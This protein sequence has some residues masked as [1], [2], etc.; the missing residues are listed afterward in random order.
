[1]PRIVLLLNKN[2]RN[3]ILDGLQEFAIHPIGKVCD[4]ETDKKACQDV[5]RIVDTRHNPSETD[6]DSED[7]EPSPDLSIVYKDSCRKRGENGRML[8]RKRSER[9]DIDELCDVRKGDEWP[10]MTENHPLTKL[11]N[12]SRRRDDEQDD[13]EPPRTPSDENKIN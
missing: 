3:V 10:R 4:Y 11:C 5:N 2:S 9:G 13:E 8:G 7:D 6:E 1:M 12:Q